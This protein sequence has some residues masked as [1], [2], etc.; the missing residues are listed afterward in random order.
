MEESVAEATEQNLDGLREKR[1][2][3]LHCFLLFVLAPQRR[4]KA[5]SRCLSYAAVE[6]LFETLVEMLCLLETLLDLHLLCDREE[7]SDDFVE[8][9][10]LHPNIFPSDRTDDA[11]D[12]L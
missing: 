2:T 10:L 1:A 8:L 9:D 3:G 7:A 11:G 12:S 6:Q 4:R 5:W